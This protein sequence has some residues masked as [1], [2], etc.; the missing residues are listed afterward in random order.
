[1]TTPENPKQE[2]AKK[3]AGFFSIVPI[4]AKLIWRY[5]R[6]LFSVD[7]LVALE[8]KQ[9]AGSGE[10]SVEEELLEQA[11]ERNKHH[12]HINPAD[13]HH[14]HGAVERRDVLSSPVIVVKKGASDERNR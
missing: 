7:T 8:K 6:R 1:M 10:R 12:Y 11:L 13:L 3:Q 5:G 14:S 4:L 9:G 2:V